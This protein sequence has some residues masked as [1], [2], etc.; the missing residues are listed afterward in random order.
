MGMTSLK[1][2]YDD[3]PSYFVGAYS[4]QVIVPI[5]LDLLIIS[6]GSS[7][8]PEELSEH[9][10][11]VIVGDLQLSESWSETIHQAPAKSMVSEIYR[12]LMEHLWPV[13]ND[14]PFAQRTATVIL[15]DYNVLQVRTKCIGRH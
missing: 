15:V 2:M 6:Q 4:L 3:A 5:L 13:I 12:I 7:F 14:N 1:D 10:E 9:L 11:A 8:S